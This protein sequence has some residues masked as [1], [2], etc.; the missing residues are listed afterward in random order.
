MTT[1]KTGERALALEMVGLKKS[2]GPV[3]VLRGISMQAAEGEV[4]SIIGSSGSGKSTLLRC[5]NLLE[6]PNAGAVSIAGELIRM[7]P[8]RYGQTPSDARQVDR[9]RARCGMVFQSFNLWTHMTVLENVIEAPVHVLKLPRAEAIERADA[10]LRR[11][12]LY[13]RRSY[14]PGHLSGGQQQRAAIARA[15]GMSRRLVLRRIILP[16][17]FRLALPAYGNEIIFLLK[18]S[19]LASTI[20]LLDLTGVARTIIA[21]TY[22]P[23]ELF[24]M[25]GAIYLMVTFL[26]TRAIKALE[27]WLSPHTRPPRPA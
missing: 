21:R 13:D 1:D 7:M 12:G 14:Y 23:I 4:I 26:I 9:L 20:T 2:F 25:A 17:A 16:R 10:L 15:L 27:H 6:I 18:A 22:M 19:A 24:A 3:E 5:I 8:T 11:V